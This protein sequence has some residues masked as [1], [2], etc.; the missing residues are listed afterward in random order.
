MTAFFSW[1]YSPLQ[2]VCSTDMTVQLRSPL[3]SPVELQERAAATK[4]QVASMTA[5]LQKLK[6]RQQQLESR[7]AILE[8]L[9]HLDA[10]QPR[11]VTDDSKIAVVRLPAVAIRTCALR[12][13]T[14]DSSLSTLST[15]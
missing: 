7:N 5:E 15:Q 2:A 11:Q 9:H 10:A 1:N 6:D 4:A 3:T 12:T 8:K 13:Y 14:I